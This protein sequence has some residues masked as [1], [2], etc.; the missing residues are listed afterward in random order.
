MARTNS[1]QTEFNAS[2]MFGDTPWVSGDDTYPVLAHS[3]YSTT[4]AN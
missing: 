1:H 2:D 4:L 3:A